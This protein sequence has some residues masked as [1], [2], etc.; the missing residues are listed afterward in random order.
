MLTWKIGVSGAGST[1]AGSVASD[2]RV[3]L[4]VRAV[5]I[6]VESNHHGNHHGVVPAA[7]PVV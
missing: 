2:S 1:C 4:A 3:A 5:R 7:G 6:A